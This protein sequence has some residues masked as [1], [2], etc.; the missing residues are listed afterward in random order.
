M[1]G[2]GVDGGGGGVG[3]QGGDCCGSRKGKGRRVSSW[4]RREEKHERR[5]QGE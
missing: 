3:V 5:E 4:P 1:C 2:W